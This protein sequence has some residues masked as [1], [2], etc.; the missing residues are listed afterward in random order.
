MPKKIPVRTCVGCNEAKPKSEFIRVVRTP[1]GEI[2]LD[3]T[4]KANGRGAYIC[5]D[6]KCL[7]KAEKSKRLDRT[8]GLTVENEVYRKLE[9]EIANG[10]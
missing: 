1:G 4:G 9:K 6:I 7:L 10:Q 5:K 3:F 2:I 8:F